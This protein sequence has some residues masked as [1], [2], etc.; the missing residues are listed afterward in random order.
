M[1]LIFLT[2][3]RYLFQYVLSWLQLYFLLYLSDKSATIVGIGQVDLSF[4]TYLMEFV[5]TI[6]ITM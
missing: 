6:A 4:L 3:E 1:F 5:F 2:R